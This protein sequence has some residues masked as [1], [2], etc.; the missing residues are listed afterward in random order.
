MIGLGNV[1]RYF[2]RKLLLKEGKALQNGVVR[3]SDVDQKVVVVEGLKL[4]FDV[5]RLHDLV[6]LAVLLPTDEFSMFV[7][8]LNLETNFMVES[9]M[10]VTVNI[11]S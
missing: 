3:S 1:E 11:S 9:L 6:D 7:S 2:G 8:E 5:G 4:D 10:R